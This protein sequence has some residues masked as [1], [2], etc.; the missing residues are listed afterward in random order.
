MPSKNGP[1]ARVAQ[2][3]ESATDPIRIATLKEVLAIMDSSRRYGYRPTPTAEN[4]RKTERNTRVNRAFIDASF[5]RHKPYTTEELE[6][7]ADERLNCVQIAVKLGR[8]PKGVSHQ[9]AK[10][11]KQ[12]EQHG[13]TL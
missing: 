5:H 12:R 13:T 3:L 6:L 9:R 2:L 11:R 10:L 7:I 8:T 4:R 1:R